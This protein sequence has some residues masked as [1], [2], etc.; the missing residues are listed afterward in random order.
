MHEIIKPVIGLK[1]WKLPET[2][3][4][5]V[6]NAF[7]AYNLKTFIKECEDVL[8]TGQDFLPIVIDSYG[9]QVY[10]LFGMADFLENCGVKVITITQGKAMSAGALLFSYGEDRYRQNCNYYDS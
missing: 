1:E 10:T 6:M 9:G 3:S 4:Y 7:G 5:V 2:P 8:R